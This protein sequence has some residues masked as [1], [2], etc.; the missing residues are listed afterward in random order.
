[1]SYASDAAN[2]QQIYPLF[3]FIHSLDLSQCL[4]H[5]SYSK[6]EDLRQKFKRKADIF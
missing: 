2:A 5:S 1:M 4:S 6:I 3:E